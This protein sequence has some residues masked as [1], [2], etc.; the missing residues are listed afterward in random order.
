MPPSPTN[1]R[2]PRLAMRH[3]A[4]SAMHHPRPHASVQL[5]HWPR[6]HSSKSIASNFLFITNL[7][8]NITERILKDELSRSGAV[9]HVTIPNVD[10]RSAGM[11][12]VSLPANADPNL[13]VTAFDGLPM[14]GK[15][16]SVRSDHDAR[17]FR[18][19][20]HLLQSPPVPTNHDS[21]PPTKDT[22]ADSNSP[23]WSL[24]SQSDV[25]HPLSPSSQRASDPPNSLPYEPKKTKPWHS[26]KRPRARYEADRHD[27]NSPPKRRL[28]NDEYSSRRHFANPVSNLNDAR[29]SYSRRSDEHRYTRQAGQSRRY[30]HYRDPPHQS[31]SREHTCSSRSGY[32]SRS[33]YPY[34][35]DREGRQERS[36]NGSRHHK[37]DSQAGKPYASQREHA[38]PRGRFD[39]VY[40]ERRTSRVYSP[41]SSGKRPRSF[42]FKSGDRNDRRFYSASSRL[43]PG[44]YPAI[45]L[46]GVPSDITDYDIRTSFT[47]FNAIHV[48]QKETP[49]LYHVLF[50]DSEDRELALRR[51]CFTFSGVR[52]TPE[53]CLTRIDRPNRPSTAGAPYPSPRTASDDRFASSYRGPKQSE[54]G[55]HKYCPDSGKTRNAYTD[56]DGFRQNPVTPSQDDTKS[57]R[58]NAM[59]VQRADFDTSHPRESP[60]TEL[61]KGGQPESTSHDIKTA[62]GGPTSPN[63]KSPRTERKEP[64]DTSEPVANAVKTYSLDAQESLPTLASGE[65]GTK[66]TT[67]VSHLD[68]IQDKKHQDGDRRT[69]GDLAA[70]ENGFKS[71]E[72]LFDAV[73]RHAIDRVSRQHAQLELKRC[74]ALVARSVSEFVSAKKAERK[75]MRLNENKNDTVHRVP[76]SANAFS[77]PDVGDRPESSPKKARISGRKEPRELNRTGSARRRVRRSR[78]SDIPD[79]DTS[80]LSNGSKTLSMFHSEGAPRKEIEPDQCQDVKR[81]M[82]ASPTKETGRMNESEMSCSTVLKSSQDSADKSKTNLGTDAIMEESHDPTEKTEQPTLHGAESSKDANQVLNND[83]ATTDVAMSGTESGAKYSTG[84]SRPSSLY[85]QNSEGVLPPAS[86]RALTSEL[87]KVLE[88]K[89]NYRHSKSS[90]LKCLHTESGLPSLGLFSRQPPL[91]TISTPT[92]EASLDQTSDQK[93]TPEPDSI[94][95]PPPKEQE[96]GSRATTKVGHP[97]RT[98]SAKASASSKKQ[99]RKNGK[100][101]K[102]KKEKKLKRA[103]NIP[104]RKTRSCSST[105]PTSP[106]VDQ[107]ELY[108]APDADQGTQTSGKHGDMSDGIVASK[109][110]IKRS[111]TESEGQAGEPD[112]SR[113][114][115]GT[116]LTVDDRDGKCA[117]TEMYIRGQSKNKR[118]KRLHLESLSGKSALSSR[119]SRQESRLYRK[120]VSKIKP[121]NDDFINLNSLQQ[122]WKK[123]QFDRSQIHGM[124]LYAKENIEPDE[125]VIEY[126]GDLIRRTVADLREK[127]YTRQGMGDSYLFRLNWNTV[128]DATRR[129]GIARFI[130][131]SCDPNVIARK[132]TIGGRSTIA[133]YSK[134]AISIGEELTYD[135]KFDY[136]AE[137]KK[138]PCLCGAANCRKYLN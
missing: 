14:F 57:S 70:S 114:V 72:E 85:V 74:E 105:V 108:I 110:G 33:P 59:V 127:E 79:P 126:I 97:A 7:N 137:D 64:S 86:T 42:Q 3:H 22:R 133:F 29:P 18:D 120:G 55:K 112:I 35:R 136:E 48:M 92:P 31:G 10:G 103:S 41:Y 16:L 61:N 73:L 52:I 135:Y 90:L 101:G 15:K 63:C 32:E 106:S 50:Y 34:S 96:E 117:R 45:A 119:Q 121:K 21:T 51:G 60:S 91:K 94:P 6:P 113:D 49:G 115:D 109:T 81:E 118:R 38:P 107:F 87:D 89:S 28:L 66:R 56:S 5:L 68:N 17:N 27:H 9:C 77:K 13:F 4:A 12:S 138:I 123:V 93:P 102:T 2:D 132:I 43:F 104:Q 23:N 80:L 20:L 98:K 84:R 111:A 134:R 30:M 26:N 88:T 47:E 39:D 37:Y 82:L 62:R 122:R 131:H 54:R 1:R 36:S 58:R 125:F 8:D 75:S 83:P 44:D 100:A 40:R 116:D 129:G 130:N 124:G 67:A 11:A 69:N 95:V 53:K 128:I 19:A 99:S 76:R 46:R 25:E 78:F 71:K 24:A 65:N